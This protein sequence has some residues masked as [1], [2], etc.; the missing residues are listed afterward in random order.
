[1]SDTEKGWVLLGLAI[2]LAVGSIFGL[3]YMARM[4]ELGRV[5]DPDHAWTC[6][7]L[8]DT[9]AEHTLDRPWVCVSPR[10]EPLTVVSPGAGKEKRS[11]AR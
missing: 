10:R 1:M 3:V 6:T 7:R 5:L 8:T 4:N 11:T 9:A 2:G